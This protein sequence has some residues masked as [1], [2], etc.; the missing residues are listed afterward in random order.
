MSL[1]HQLKFGVDAGK[2]GVNSC[3]PFEQISGRVI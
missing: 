1:D 2:T 3:C